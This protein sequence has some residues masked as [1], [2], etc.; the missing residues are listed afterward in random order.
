M[1]VELQRAEIAKQMQEQVT[2]ALKEKAAMEDTIL[3]QK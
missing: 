3:Q 1:N 2:T